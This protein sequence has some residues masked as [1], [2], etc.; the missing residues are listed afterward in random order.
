MGGFS[1]LTT[2]GP[3]LGVP[4]RRRIPLASSGLFA[5]AR[6]GGRA[7]LWVRPD[8]PEPAAAAASRRDRTRRDRLATVCPAG[9]DVRIGGV[10]DPLGVGVRVGN[11]GPLAVEAEAC[12]PRVV[13]QGV[14]GVVGVAGPCPGGLNAGDRSSGVFPCGACRPRAGRP[15]RG[16]PRGG[17]FF[18]RRGGGA[19]R[20]L[21]VGAEVLF[22]ARAGRSESEPGRLT[23]ARAVGGRGEAAVGL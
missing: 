9:V 12:T 15:P 17:V 8:G 6:G 21:C 3:P 7:R 23:L 13:T 20:G 14:V 1:R 16:F 19:R 4:W 2:R 5:I 11:P 18:V 22:R 10:P